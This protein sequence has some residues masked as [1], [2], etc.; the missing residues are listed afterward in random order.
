MENSKKKID[1][2][3]LNKEMW[4]IK[5]PRSVAQQWEKVP[6]GT[7]V[8]TMK[9]TK[10]DNG[11][12]ENAFY[13]N[14]DLL[15]GV[16][17]GGS[18]YKLHPTELVDKKIAILSETGKDIKKRCNGFRGEKLVM[19]GHANTKLICKP[20]FDETYIKCKKKDI[21]TAYL[22]KQTTQVIEVPV[23][24]PVYQKPNRKLD[25]NR[26]YRADKYDVMETIFEAFEKQQF[27]SLKDLAK[28]TAQPVIY[29]KELLNE[30]CDYNLNHPNKNL[31]ELKKEYRHYT[32]IEELSEHDSD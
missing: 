14:P 18:E 8:M 22:P 17:G 16:L 2:T 31:W 32:E 21:I 7:E 27:Y 11:K 28:I 15:D 6:S 20:V 23:P 3:D 25:R 26:K 10:T 29:L 4:L 5:V 9:V 12:Q 13:L 1:V 24:P 30:V 19:K